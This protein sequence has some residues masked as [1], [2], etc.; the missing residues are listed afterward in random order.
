VLEIREL[1][2]SFEQPGGGR[3][4]ILDIDSLSAAPGEQVV[5]IGQS[6][7]GKT[8]LVALDLWHLYA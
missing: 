7:G 2:K 1:K 5:L 6:G 8:T 3:L 4:P